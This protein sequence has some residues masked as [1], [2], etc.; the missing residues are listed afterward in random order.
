MNNDYFKYYKKTS[1]EEFI[2]KMLSYGKP[3]ETSLVGA[4]DDEG[5]GSRRDIDLPLHRDGDYSTEFKDKIDYV[6]LYCLRGGD[7]ET[8]IEF[9]NKVKK[10][11]LKPKEAIIF[12][13]KLCRH[14]REG[15]VGDRVLLRVWISSR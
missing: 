1:L 7:A 6:G 14:G 13:N 3:L 9:E 8:I 11:R 10:I 12:N 5:R 15:I 2:F 4:F